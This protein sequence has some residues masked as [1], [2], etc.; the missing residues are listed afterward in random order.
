VVRSE[1]EDGLDSDV[2]G[3]VR[4]FWLQDGTLVRERLLSLC[5]R[6][7]SFHYNFETPAFPVTNYRAR[8]RL[9]PSP[10]PPDLRRVGGGVRRGAGRRGQVCRDHLERRVPGRLE[11][12]EGGAARARARGGAL[13]HGIPAA[14][15]LVLDGHTRAGRGGVGHHPRLR[16]DDGWHPDITN[17]HM[18]GGTRPDKVSA[19][20]TSCSARGT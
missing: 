18:L 7:T 5:D 6:T 13:W 17:M 14:Q 19:R 16:L 9:M 12:A 1:I 10:P 2:V 11:R 8:V 4:R 15:G 3:C 20:A